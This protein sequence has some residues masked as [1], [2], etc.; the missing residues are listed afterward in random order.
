MVGESVS[1]E[2]G[3]L[4][5]YRDNV[6]GLQDKIRDALQEILCRAALPT[7]PAD[8]G[9]GVSANGVDEIKLPLKPTQTK[10]IAAQARLAPYKRGEETVV[11][12]AVRYTSELVM[13]QS[14]FTGSE[15]G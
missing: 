4:P 5:E 12:T 7:A 10:N 2:C 8:H 6:F 3:P 9:I 15:E 14:A 13:S 1:F 11:N